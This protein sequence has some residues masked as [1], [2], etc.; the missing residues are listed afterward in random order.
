MVTPINN[1]DR[2]SMALLLVF[3]VMATVL[4]Y[5]VG[6]RVNEYFRRETVTS[7]TQEF[8]MAMSFPAVTLCSFNR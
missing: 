5:H 3:T 7:I 8:E 1:T 2:L 4:L 6:A